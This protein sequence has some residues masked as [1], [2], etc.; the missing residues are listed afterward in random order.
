MSKED[1]ETLLK[2]LLRCGSRDLDKFG[3]MMAT[4]DNFDISIYDIIENTNST[5]IEINALLN[6]IITLIF[7]KVMDLIEDSIDEYDE[8]YEKNEDNKN[9]K[10]HTF[11]A[12]KLV[13][14]VNKIRND[15]NPYIDYMDSFFD[16]NLDDIDLN[17]LPDFPSEE[18]IKIIE[19]WE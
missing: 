19:N 9:D 14:K 8:K 5:G 13:Q 17:N 2:E 10:D 3:D 1:M 6:S 12:E 7:Y 18:Y 16:N 4:A 15:F 11:N